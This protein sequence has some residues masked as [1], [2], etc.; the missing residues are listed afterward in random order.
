MLYFSHQ[1]YYDVQ[2][3]GVNENAGLSES[4]SGKR[5]SEQRPASG[6]VRAADKGL[7]VLRQTDQRKCCHLPLLRL[8]GEPISATAPDSRRQ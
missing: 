6:T 7:S 1:S 3:K 4:I 5:I 2:R 8:S